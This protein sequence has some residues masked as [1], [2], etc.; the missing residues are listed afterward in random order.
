MSSTTTRYISRIDV[1]YPYA[2]RDNDTQTFRDN[3]TNIAQALTAANTEIETVSQ[4]VDAITVNNVVSLSSGTDLRNFTDTS[5]ETVILTAP[6]ITGTGKYIFAYDSTDV[7][8][9]DNGTSTFVAIDGR[10]W[11]NNT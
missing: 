4:R 10:R 3:F 5:I 11:K 1:N 8:S 7:V 6:L 2:G 9:L